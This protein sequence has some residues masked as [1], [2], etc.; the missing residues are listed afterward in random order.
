MILL[1]MGVGEQCYREA[2]L[3]LETDS[4]PPEGAGPLDFMPLRARLDLLRIVKGIRGTVAIAG[5]EF[6]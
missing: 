6:R 4:R 2:T 1:W 5:D 3:V